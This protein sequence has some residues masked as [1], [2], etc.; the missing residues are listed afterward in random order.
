MLR[1]ERTGERTY[2]FEHFG[3]MA[4]LR[5]R[6]A[7][8]IVTAVMFRAAASIVVLIV[9]AG[10]RPARA[11]CDEEAT[12]LR[13]HLEDERGRAR[14]WNTVWAVLFGAAAVGQAAFAIAEVSPTGGTYDAD[15]RE[16]LIVGASKATVGVVSKIAMPLRIRVPSTTGDPC[17]DV[18]VLRAALADAGKREARS[19]WL[20]HIGGTV[21]NLA[22]ATILTVRRSFKVGAISFAISYPVGPASAYTQPRRSWHRWREQRA[23]WVVGASADGD[24]ARLW[25]GGH[26]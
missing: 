12:S 19:F 20:T 15:D 17:S 21:V 4:L 23:S 5:M 7:Y 14:R 16:T 22:G 9:L 6:E 1:V 2:A 24:G 10:A 11:T 18:V 25:L 26:W 3:Q 13:A 8:W